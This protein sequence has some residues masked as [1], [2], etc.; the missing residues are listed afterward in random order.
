MQP[1]PEFGA[2]VLSVDLEDSLRAQRQANE[3]ENPVDTA[4]WRRTRSSGLPDPGIRVVGRQTRFAGN[5]AC[6]NA[7]EPTMCSGRLGREQ[8]PSYGLVSGGRKR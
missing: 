2:D 5:E 6:L 7:A 8:V 1:R 3:V 4:R